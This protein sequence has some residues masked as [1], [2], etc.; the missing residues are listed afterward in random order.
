MDHALRVRVGHDLAQLVEDE[1][2]AG[3]SASV[4]SRDSRLERLVE[5]PAFDHRHR[6]VRPSVPPRSRGRRRGTTPGCSSWAA[7][8]ASTRNR[9]DASL[10]IAVEHLHRERPIEHGVPDVQHD[11]PCRRARPPRA[12]RSDRPPARSGLAARAAAVRS[13]PTAAARAVASSV[14]ARDARGTDRRSSLVRPPRRRRASRRRGARPRDPGSDR[15]RVPRTARGPDRQGDLG[16]LELV[17]VRLAGLQV[18]GV[19]PLEVEV[20]RVGIDLRIHDQGPSRPSAGGLPAADARTGP[21]SS[22]SIITRKRSTKPCAAS[23]PH[24]LHPEIGS[25]DQEL[26]SVAEAGVVRDR[27]K[28]RRLL[29]EAAVEEAVRQP[30][31]RVARQEEP[32]QAHAGADRGGRGVLRGRPS[33][34]R[35]R[36]RCRR[37]SGR[38]SRTP[39]RSGPKGPRASRDGIASRGG[40]RPGR[41]RRASRRAR[42]GRGAT[43]RRRSSSCA[44]ALSASRRSAE[45]SCRSP[46]S[47]PRSPRRSSPRP[48]RHC[49]GGR[50]PRRA[51]RSPRSR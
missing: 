3:Q 51:S 16:I 29:H 23:S 32:G 49:R 48:L 42:P 15:A 50:A 39:R 44:G 36:R 43:S 34:G 20:H 46:S 47:R 41:R 12:G 14:R 28:E 1:Q 38:G 26:P 5:G 40:A 8:F 13:P 6:E 27:R 33:D 17:L 21:S 4:R 19:D 9:R 45:P 10:C 7:T 22:V 35:P 37:C 30:S 24:P 2:R 25:E 31:V 18:V 11:P